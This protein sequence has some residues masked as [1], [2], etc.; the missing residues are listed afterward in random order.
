MSHLFG[1]LLFLWLLFLSFLFHLD[2]SKPK[3][4]RMFH[5]WNDSRENLPLLDPGVYRGDGGTR[6]FFERGS[7]CVPLGLLEPLLAVFWAR[8]PLLS[9]SSPVLLPFGA[10]VYQFNICV[11]FFDIWSSSPVCWP[12]LFLLY[13]FEFSPRSLF[14]EFLLY[15][16]LPCYFS[17]PDWHFTLVSSAV[18]VYLSSI[19]SIWLTTTSVKGRH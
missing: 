7:V 9:S 18:K 17:G 13:S 6:V 15:E 5:K 10:G 16:S 11:S 2:L 1:F 3:C 4:N 14:V 19:P 12:A 8:L